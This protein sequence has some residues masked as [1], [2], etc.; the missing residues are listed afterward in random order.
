MQ[1]GCAWPV[2]VFSPLAVRARS[3]ARVAGILLVSFVNDMFGSERGTSAGPS[4]LSTGK[5]HAGAGFI[6]EAFWNRGYSTEVPLWKQPSR[7]A[8]QSAYGRAGDELLE[9]Q[10]G[11]APGIV[12]ND[13]VFLE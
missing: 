7:K 6:V 13:A 5:P 11:E 1:T 8:K 12:A 10:A 4:L 3:A 9:H 2:S